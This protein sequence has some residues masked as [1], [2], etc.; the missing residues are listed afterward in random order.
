[1]T[2]A[3]ATGGWGWCPAR[4]LQASARCT[5]RHQ[6]G[7]DRSYGPAVLCHALQCAARPRFL[8]ECGHPQVLSFPQ[9]PCANPSSC[10]KDPGSLG[11]S[12]SLA[13]RQVV[14]RFT[15][16]DGAPPSKEPTG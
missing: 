3:H 11:P 13:R 2:C 10:S 14:C 6:G 9:G 7:Q 12:T 8:K 4:A 16:Q 15:T 1:M 5:G